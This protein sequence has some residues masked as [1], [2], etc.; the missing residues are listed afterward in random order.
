MEPVEQQLGEAGH[1]IT[2]IR[3]KAEWLANPMIAHDADVLFIDGHLTV[4]SAIME[5]AP[6]LRAIIA[7]TTGT[8]GIDLVAATRAAIIV[9][10]GQLPQNYHSMAEATVMLI[11]TSLYDLKGSEENLRSKADRPSDPPG[12]MLQGKT[13]GILGMGKV[14]Q[15]VCERLRGWGAKL[16]A[17]VRRPE[18]EYPGVEIL[19]LDDVLRTSDVIVVLL[20][21]TDLTRNLLDEQKLRYTKPDSVLINVAR[22]GIIDEA[23]LCRVVLDGHF[24][25]VALDVFEQE[26]LPTTSPLR[27][28]PRTT[29]TPHRV[30]HTQETYE[31]FPVA[32]LENIQNV[33]QGKPPVYIRNPD[34]IPSWLARWSAQA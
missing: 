6:R 9:G 13:V 10:N 30:G 22:G 24:R 16:Q 18:A 25:H 27:V 4:G 26:P 34:A 3:T 23:A 12:R 21:L 17:A 7:P 32:A 33:L 8:E 31:A 20:G 11:L 5:A 2:R 29:L 28:L 19:P 1:Q 14:G 15:A